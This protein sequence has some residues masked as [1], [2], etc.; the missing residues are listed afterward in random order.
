MGVSL[1]ISSDRG[2][3]HL[4]NNPELRVYCMIVDILEFNLDMLPLLFAR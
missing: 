4:V 3:T 2:T 1:K